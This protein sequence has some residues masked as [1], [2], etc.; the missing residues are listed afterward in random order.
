M[1][2]CSVLSGMRMLVWDVSACADF[3]S[4]AVWCRWSSALREPMWGRQRSEIRAD[5][6]RPRPSFAACSES[7]SRG[8]RGS[9]RARLCGPSGRPDGRK[10]LRSW[11]TDP[12]IGRQARR[13]PVARTGAKMSYPIKRR[14]G[15]KVAN[16]K[17]GC[18]PAG[19][20]V[21]VYCSSWT[22][23]EM[24]ALTVWPSFYERFELHSALDKSG[25][26]EI[27]LMARVTP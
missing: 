1:V 10:R 21:L 2:R 16:N 7:F 25:R 17:I 12:A 23:T 3:E 18:L 5:R 4:G 9:C 19:C 26:A 6:K 24:V 13:R 27:P 8:R 15:R 11:W 14:R 22:K 20:R